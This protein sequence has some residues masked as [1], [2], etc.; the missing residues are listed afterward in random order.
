MLRLHMSRKI[1]V[2]KYTSMKWFSNDKDLARS[3]QVRS[4]RARFC[5]AY[6]TCVAV[7]KSSNANTAV[8]GYRFHGCR[9][10]LARVLARA[11]AL[12]L[13][14]NPRPP[15]L[16]AAVAGEVGSDVRG[17]WQSCRAIFSCITAP[18]PRNKKAWQKARNGRCFWQVR[19]QADL[20]VTNVSIVPY[21]AGYY[22][23][24][25]FTYALNFIYTGCTQTRV[26]AGGTDRVGCKSP[27]P[28]L[29]L[30]SWFSWIYKS[31]VRS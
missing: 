11:G 16:S 7:R 31:T 9:Y 25:V 1:S 17:E 5:T 3:I 20:R 21:S 18:T 27:P 30:L 13:L 14:V 24:S 23:R 22:Y 26:C 4:C 28:T 15:P 8:P 29:W 19:A 12:L 2:A 10:I 6:F